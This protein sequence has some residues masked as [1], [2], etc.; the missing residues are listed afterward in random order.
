MRLDERFDE[1]Q[2]AVERGRSVIV[3]G[4][5]RLLRLLRLL[6][7]GVGSAVSRFRIAAAAATAPIP[8]R[9]LR[10]RVIF[11]H[12]GKVIGVGLENLIVRLED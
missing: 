8:P 1:G 5:F 12:N 3:G 4:L 9:F 2:N 10:G 6:R 11:I 7:S